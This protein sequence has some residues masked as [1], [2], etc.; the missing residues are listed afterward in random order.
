MS[1][2]LETHRPVT[3]D[4]AGRLRDALESSSYDP[5]GMALCMS[6]GGYKSGA[7][8]LGALIRLNELGLLRRL[9]RISSVSGGS[10]TNAYLGLKWRSLDWSDKSVARNL[11][12]EVVRP[13]QR[14]YTQI[15]SDFWN[16]A[17][18]LALPGRSGADGVEKTYRKHL[19]QDA[20]LQDFPDE[21]DA[22]RFVIL[23]TNF[24]LNTVWRFAKPYAADYRVGEVRAPR[25]PLSKIVAASSGFPPFFCPITIDLAGTQLNHFEGADRHRPPYTQRLKLADG[26]VYDN[27][28]LE[29][30]WKRYGVLLVSNAGDPFD[31]ST[32]PPRHW[33]PVLRRCLSMIHRQA[34]NNRVRWLLSLAISKRRALA[35]WPLR[36]AVSD[37]A[38]R[39]TLSMSP[40]DAE[41]AQNEPVRLKSLGFE[42]FQRLVRLGYSLSDAA[43]RSYIAPGAPPPSDW[44]NLPSR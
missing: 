8:Q 29:P 18:G 28:G 20:T 44:P 9:K 19:F 14:F 27:M 34:E 22:P 31:E 32:D 13:L 43:V 21:P 15:D 3:G 24:E 26:G 4:V 30:I 12:E 2:D 17:L 37:Y 35:Y 42:A 25:F 1:E 7:Y 10:I 39:G 11:H 36:N 41:A 23:A 6:G 5:E 38:A 16:I 40:E 33:M